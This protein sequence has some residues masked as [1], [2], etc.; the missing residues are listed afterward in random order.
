[1]ALAQ[2]PELANENHCFAAVPQLSRPDANRY[3]ET[4]MMQT[5]E[6]KFAAQRKDFDLEVTKTSSSRAKIDSI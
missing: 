4:Q 2:A 6:E 3:G 5:K 1:M